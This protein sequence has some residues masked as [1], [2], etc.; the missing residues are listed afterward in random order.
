MVLVRRRTD[1]VDSLIRELKTHDI[2]VA[3]IDRMVLT[4]QLAVRDLMALATFALLPDDDLNVAVVL[5]Y[6]F[7]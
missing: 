3:G 1:F 2:N 7:C 6:L 5:L 4:S